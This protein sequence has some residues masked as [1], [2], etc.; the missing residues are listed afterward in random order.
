MD[1]RRSDLYFVV[2]VVAAIVLADWKA[3]GANT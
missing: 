2:G 3:R 1:R